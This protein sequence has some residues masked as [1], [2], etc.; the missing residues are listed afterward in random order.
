MEMCE[1]T[2]TLTD[3]ESLTTIFMNADG[4]HRLEDDLIRFPDVA[5]IA[6][7]RIPAD[8]DPETPMPD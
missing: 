4:P 1:M 7:D 6:W 3:W 5:L 8:V 2:M